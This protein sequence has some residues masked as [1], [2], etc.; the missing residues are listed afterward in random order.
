MNCDGCMCASIL[1]PLLQW[2][3]VHSFANCVPAHA[4]H[5]KIAAELKT[6]MT[7]ASHSPSGMTEN[8]RAPN[9]AATAKNPISSELNT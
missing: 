8:P 5:L 6:H 7:H 9:S 3:G 4:L 1:S 2:N